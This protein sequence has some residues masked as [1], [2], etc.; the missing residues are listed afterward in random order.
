M[1]S[2]WTAMRA[3]VYTSLFV[4]LWGW[5]ALSR[6]EVQ[7]GS[8]ESTPCQSENITRLHSGICF[9]QFPVLGGA[10]PYAAAASRSVVPVLLAPA[11]HPA[12]P[13]VMVPGRRVAGS[14]NGWRR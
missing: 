10:S 8:R 4:W 6:I 2:L 7:N 12:R 1:R 5:V 14:R 9:M 3:L 13:R 11:W